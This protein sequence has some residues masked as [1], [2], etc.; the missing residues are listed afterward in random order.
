M[1]YLK[2]KFRS[3]KKLPTWFFWLPA[4]LMQ[5]LGLLAYRVRIEDPHGYM[6]VKKGCIVPIWHN[7]LFSFPLVFPKKYRVR[8]TA[9]IS[10]SRDGQYVADFIAQFG[11]E[12]LRG[13][14]SKRGAM[15]QLAA[16]EK[17]R[18]EQSCIIFTPDGPRG[19][20]YVMKPGPIHLAGVTGAEIVP[21]SINYSRCWSFRSWDGFQIPKP[22][23]KI[24]LVIGDPIAV[25]PHLDHD[26]IEQYR[27]RVEE[28]LLKITIDPPAAARH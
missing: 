11:I 6:E 21:V 7:R 2:R 24:T 28:A 12:S 16:I 27:K 25:P 19:P 23:A 20:R 10:A 22:W 3:I 9:M 18:D 14:S 5:L 17:I 26:G 13:S 15:A 4:R 1:N 8:T